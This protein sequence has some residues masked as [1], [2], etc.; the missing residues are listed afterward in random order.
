MFLRLSVDDFLGIS[1][2]LP[3]AGKLAILEV[4]EKLEDA[5]KMEEELDSGY[6]IED[7]LLRSWVKAELG[8]NFL[9]RS[10]AYRGKVIRSFEGATYNEMDFD[11]R[12]DILLV[13]RPLEVLVDGSL[14]LAWKKL[15]ETKSPKLED[16]KGNH[17][18]EVFPRNSDQ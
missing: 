16:S 15:S 2:S 11:K 4:P 17:E 8:T 18:D 6:R 5:M 12:R 9:L 10:V 13:L 3:A 1:M 14:I 7:L